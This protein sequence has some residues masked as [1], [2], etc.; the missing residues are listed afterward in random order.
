VSAFPYPHYDTMELKDI[1][2]VQRPTFDPTSWLPEVMEWMPA[3]AEEWVDEREDTVALVHEIPGGSVPTL[4][5]C[6]L[7]T[8]HARAGYQK[9]RSLRDDPARC[10]HPTVTVSVRMTGQVSGSCSK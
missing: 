4:F 9:V 10:I 7:D 8:V 2:A 6:H 5:A 1:L 3:D